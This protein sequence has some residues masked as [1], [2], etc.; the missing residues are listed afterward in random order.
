M[1]QFGQQ[2]KIWLLS[3]I[4][5]FSTADEAAGLEPSLVCLV[6]FFS[7]AQ[8]SQGLELK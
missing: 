2:M 1:Q 6:C 4:D 3:G 5:L 7:L 8:L